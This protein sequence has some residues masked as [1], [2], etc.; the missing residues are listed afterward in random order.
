MIAVLSVRR[1]VM[2]G[3]T[4]R[5]AKLI[6]E[7]PL[8]GTTLGAV[9]AWTTEVEFAYEHG[10]LYLLDGAD[11]WSDAERRVD[12]RMPE[13]AGFFVALAVGGWG[14]KPGLAL[15]GWDRVA[16]FSLT[17]PSGTLALASG[18]CG[19]VKLEIAPGAYR[20]RWSGRAREF[21]LQLWPGPP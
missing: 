19:A 15:G 3:E 11:H 20:A 9:Q 7:P 12:L 10:H 8:A 1:S 4:S 16:D 2:H 6:G 13:P 14:A 18:N 21:R 17:L 5:R